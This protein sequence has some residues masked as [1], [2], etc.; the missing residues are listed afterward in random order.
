VAGEGALA[1]TIDVEGSKQPYQGVVSLQGN[2]IAG[3]LET[4]FTQSEQLNTRIWLAADSKAVSGL[5]LQQLPSTDNHDKEED[6]EHWSR[7]SHLASTV[8]PIE[9]LE[10]GAG[11]L[12]HR[13]FHEEEC[14]LL[15]TTGLSFSCNCSR[16]RVGETIGLLGEDDAKALLEEQGDIEVACEFC[17]EHYQFDKVDVARL[18]FDTPRENSD[19]K[20]VH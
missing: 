6:E 10:L 18:F 7:I 17:N 15:T 16:E 11:T 9:L 8:K 14:R 2:S 13:L 4:Y 5:F 12:L 1:I 20:T 3:V 19:S